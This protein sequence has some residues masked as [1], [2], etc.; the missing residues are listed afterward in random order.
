MPGPTSAIAAAVAVEGLLLQVGNG[1]SP[2]VYNT[3]SNI[4]DWNEPLIAD[5]VDVTNVGDKWRRRI[6][7]LLDMGKM[8]FKLFWVMTEPSHSNIVRSGIQGIRYI[9]TQQILASWQIVYPDGLQSVDNFLAYVTS[10]SVTGKVGGVFEA[11][12]ELSNSGAP[13]LV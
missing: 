1:A 11:E 9:Y 5:T 7:T 8:K 2:Q 10:F 6:S 3:V 4:Q 13:Y 12:I